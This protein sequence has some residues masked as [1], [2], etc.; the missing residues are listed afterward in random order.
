MVIG[1][2]KEENESSFVTGRKRGKKSLKI[3]LKNKY[4]ESII[5]LKYV[6]NL[7]FSWFI[8]LK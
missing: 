5:R 3:K 6:Y 8:Y 1:I 7:I 2:I 4:Y